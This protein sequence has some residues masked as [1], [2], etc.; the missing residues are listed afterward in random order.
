RSLGLL[1]YFPLAGGLLAG[2]YRKGEA[3][4]AG[5][6]FASTPKFFKYHG[7]DANFATTG[8][9]QAFAAARG[10]TLLELAFSWLPA[11]PPAGSIIAGAT[12]AQQIEQNVAAAD[13]T[14][15]AAEIAEIDRLTQPEPFP[16]G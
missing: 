12:S 15:D 5:T 3:P 2:K 4:P 13:W 9:L 1:P 16:I 10:R 7:T 14:L 8:R 11:R 6:R